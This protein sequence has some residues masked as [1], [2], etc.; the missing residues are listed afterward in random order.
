MYSHRL[1]F[2]AYQGGQEIGYRPHN[3]NI[4]IT[5]LMVDAVVNGNRNCEDVIGI[6]QGGLLRGDHLKEDM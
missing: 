3:H 4:I 5:I 1:A 6:S 2:T